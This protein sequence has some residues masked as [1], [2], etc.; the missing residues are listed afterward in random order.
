MSKRYTKVCN[1]L[2]LTDNDNIGPIRESDSGTL[3]D[4]VITE[5]YEVV[6]DDIYT[7]REQQVDALVSSLESW[8]ETL[9]YV[10]D[11]IARNRKD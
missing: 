6:Y 11:A 1:L 9:G 8:Q 2:A 10:I 4:M 7:T 3:A 5:A